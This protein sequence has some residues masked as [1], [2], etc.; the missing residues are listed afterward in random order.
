VLVRATHAALNPADAAQRAGR[1]PAPPGSPQDVPGLEVCGVVATCGRAVLDW[2]EGDRVFGLVGGGGLASAVAVHER[3]VARVPDSLSDV[4]AAATVEAFI[5]AH[6][7]AFTRARLEMGETLLVNGATGGVGL[8]AVQLG[9]AAG[10]RVLATARSHHDR[11]SALGAE[12]VELADASGVDAIVELVGGPNLAGDLA[13]LATLGRIVIVGTGAGA[14]V[15]L[16]LR[17]VMGKRATIVGT[18]LRARPME[19]K[20]DAVRAFARSVVPLLASGR[21][22][23]FV[24]RVFPVAEAAQAFDHLVAPGKF[25][26]VLL[27]F[28]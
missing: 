22:R 10:A 28:P 25:G 16:S 4:D 1:Y 26:K 5:T 19:Q 17:A 20:A 6:D 11:L 2:R 23:P 13:A 7:A 3:H 24:D 8:A 12:P 27:E 14:D 15:D 9:I 21:V 18:L